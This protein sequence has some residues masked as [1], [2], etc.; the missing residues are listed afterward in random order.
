MGGDSGV[1]GRVVKGVETKAESV[2]VAHSK[3]ITHPIGLFCSMPY[4]N[5]F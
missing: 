3:S 1:H 5:P 4:S 2:H